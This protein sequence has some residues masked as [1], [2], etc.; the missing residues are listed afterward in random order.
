MLIISFLGLVC[1]STSYAL[2]GAWAGFAMTFISMLRNMIFLI[3]EQKNG[4]SN[5]IT[6]KDI[7]ILFVLCFT[8]I[9][10]SIITY[11]GFF[12]LFSLTA[13]ILYTVSVWQKDIIIYKA[14][15]IPVFIFDMIYNISVGS[16]VGALLEFILVFNSIFGFVSEIK[17]KNK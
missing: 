9:L 17:N 7:L 11:N 15:G 6:K 2:L 12:S 13:T 14:L 5:I 10:F 4:K 1:C 16:Y 8:S 3:D